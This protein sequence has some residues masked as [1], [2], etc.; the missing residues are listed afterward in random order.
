MSESNPVRVI[1]NQGDNTVLH[2]L[3][4]SIASGS[5]LDIVTPAFSIFALN[6][7]MGQLRKL[8]R[9][10]IILTEDIFEQPVSD[11]LRRYEIAQKRNQIAGNNYEIRL[12]N[13]MMNASIAKD[14]SKMIKRKIE[15][16]KIKGQTTM[17]PMLILN[18]NTEGASSFVIQSTFSFTG[19]GIGLTESSNLTPMTALMNLSEVNASMT[20]SFNSAWND[21]SKTV[22]VDQSVIDRIQKMAQ[23]KSP[24]WLYFVSLYH[25]FNDRLDELDEDNIIRKGTGF[26]ETKVWNALYP[27]QRDGVV[28]LIEKLEKYNGALLADSVGLGKTFSA[29]AVIKYYELRNDRVLVLAPKRLR[30]NWVTWTQNTKTNFLAADRFGFDVLNHTDLSR[31]SGYSGDIN[32]S[33]LNWANYDLVVI[34]ESHNF[35]NNNHYDGRQSRY[36]RLMEDIIKQGTKT[37]VLML[38]A[39]PVNNRMNDIKNQINFITEGDEHA[40]RKYGVANIDEELRRAQ[41]R[42]NEWSLLQPSKRTTQRFLDMVNPGYFEILDRFTIARSRKHIEKFYDSSALGSFPIRLRPKTIMSQIDL[43]GQFPPLSDTYESIGRLRLALFQPMAYVMPNKKAKYAALYDTKTGKGNATFRQ[44]DRE[45][46]LTGLIRTNLLKR[47]ESSVNSFGL[48]LQRMLDSVDDAIRKIDEAN[49]NVDELA[50]ITA[51]EDDDDIADAFDAEAVGKKVKIL[52]GDIDRIRWRQD[53]EDD[54]DILRNLANDATAVK[55]ENDAKL[56][57]LY[58]LMEEKWQHPLNVNNKKII[59]FTAFADTAAYLY[60]NLATT[61]KSK[62]G[63]NTALITGGQSKNKTNMVGV[64]VTDMNDI[65]L[66]FAP[67]AKQRDADD[68]RA[69][70]EIDV[71]IATD[72][73]SEGQNLQD[74]DYLVNYDIH[75]NPVRIIQR[76]GRIDRIGSTNSQIQL[77]NF[78]PDVDLDVYLDLEDRVRS[79]MTLLDVSATGDD[80]VLQTE[81][82]HTDLDYRREQLQQLQNEVVDLEDM[83]GSI[84]I[85]DLTFNEFK[86]DLT[87]ALKEHEAEL[88]RAPK[89]MY[90]VTSVSLLNEAVPGVILVLRQSGEIQRQ[91][92]SLAPFLL[93]YMS[94]D[95]EVKLNYMYA[96]QILDYF[97]R[98]C[99]GQTG[100][101]EDALT[102]FNA[103]TNG[104][105]DMSHYSELLNEAIQSI[106]GKKIEVGINSLFSPG[107]TA[108]DAADAVAQESDFEL[109]SF[110][111]VEEAPDGNK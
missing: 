14:I 7:L 3:Q 37:K 59:I 42:F 6:A 34:D 1:T 47:L 11:Y 30:E 81:R 23:E 41:T 16:K 55:P 2:L 98:L 69:P 36:E 43:S 19:D 56:A 78:W 100:I 50:S 83:N 67:L 92:N 15:F 102:R 104:G 73:I 89:G 53:L 62:Y 93:V 39:T 26:K 70:E 76:F 5:S 17:A 61:I 77:V 54:R 75:W 48:T 25:L 58:G 64:K 51:F 21:K 91:D 96:K 90:A 9:V 24:E 106:K 105:R 107:G 27:F 72:A 80:N 74:A 71:L 57:D 20:D 95:G 88:N 32:L 84:S 44:E 109:I 35:R 85:T 46:A 33:T 28:G 22:S 65:L 79:R 31:T 45:Q 97:K 4:T 68:R 13:Q 63:L 52:I 111:I 18:G 40:L 103:E 10:R 87:G 101:L 60:D 8:S 94:T 86:Q 99:L 49:Q 82:E 38:S 29:L 12:R 110:L 66:N 108:M